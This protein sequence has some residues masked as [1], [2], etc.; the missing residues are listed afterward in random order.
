MITIAIY[1]NAGYQSSQ[2][3]MQGN[4][5]MVAPRSEHSTERREKLLAAAAGIFF[6]QGYAATSID[7]IIART[8]GSKRNIYNEFGN[9]EGLFTA[10]VSTHAEKA[11]SSLEIQTVEGRTLRDT[12]MSFGRQLMSEFMSAELIGLYRV[13]V[14]EAPRNP[15]LGRIYYD[16]GPGRGTTQLAGFLKAAMARGE[17]RAGDCTLLANHFIGLMRDN[18][19]L[20]VVLGLRPPPDETETMAA[21]QSAIELFL[22]GVTPR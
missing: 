9:K 13:V 15:D 18:L 10:L 2:R 4:D 5:S 22:T 11:L 19:H 20:K 8:G 7:A 6:E 17:I 14:A 3:M 1:G 21:V 12:L 16:Y